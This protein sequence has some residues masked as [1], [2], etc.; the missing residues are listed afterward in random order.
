MLANVVAAQR[1]ACALCILWDLCVCMCVVCVVCEGEY[2]TTDGCF[3]WHCCC[4]VYVGNLC[5]CV[6]VCV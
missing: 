4:T 2:V 6:C 3:A 1:S 5:V